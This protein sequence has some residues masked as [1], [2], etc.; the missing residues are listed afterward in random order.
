MLKSIQTGGG[1]VY[2]DYFNLREIPFSLTP[3]THFFYAGAERGETLEALRYAS[4]HTE[5][6]ITM[7]GEVGTGKTLLSRMLVEQKPANVEIVCVSNPGLSRDE[8]V[9]LIAVELKVRNLTGLRSVDI[10][11]KLEARLI[12]LHAKGKRVLVLIDEAHVMSPSALEEVRLLSNLE[13]N[14]HKLLRIMLVGQDELNRTLATPEMRPL[15]E[16][17]TERFPLG[18]L[19]TSEVAEYLSFRLRKAGASPGLFSHRAVVAIAR[20][21]KGINRRVN[22]LAEKA[23]MAAYVC[24]SR[25][26]ELEHAKAAIREAAFSGLVMGETRLSSPIQSLK[27]LLGLKYFLGTGKANLSW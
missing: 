2:L 21:S 14:R 24:E 20:E 15:R 25:T 1:P 5:G 6:V 9:Q 8:I 17:V 16:R 18:L 27:K 22:I 12:Y 13:T 10:L 4:L 19:S 23:L 11:T 26:V 3:N 7:T